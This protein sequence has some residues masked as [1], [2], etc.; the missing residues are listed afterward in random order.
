M[1]INPHGKAFFDL[2]SYSHQGQGSE[3]QCYECK[4][5]LSECVHSKQKTPHNFDPRR[6][7]DPIFGTKRS[8]LS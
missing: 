2:K 3:F 6:P 5:T 8:F 1:R 7:E 4:N